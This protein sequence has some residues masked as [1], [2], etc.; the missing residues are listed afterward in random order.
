MTGA[1][2]LAHL[3][4]LLPAIV[5]VACGGAGEET[6]SPAPPASV[7]ATAPLPTPSRPPSIVVVDGTEEIPATPAVP[8]YFD[9]PEYGIQAFLFWDP[10]TAERD[11]ELIQE[12]GFGWVKQGFAWRDIEPF[13]G[14]EPDWWKPDKVVEL[15]EAA[16]LKP[17]VRIDRQPFWAQV[18]EWPPIENGPPADYE[19]FGAFCGRLAA[20]YR[21]RIHAYQVWNEPNLSREWGD[22]APDAAAYTELLRVCYEAIKAADPLAIVISA[23]LAPTGTELPEAIPD[24]EYLQA[25]YDAGASAYFDVLGLNAPGYKAPPELDPDVVADPEAGYGGNRWMSFR[26]VEDMRAIMEANGDADKQIAILEMGW[27]LEQDIHESYAWFGVDEEKQAEYLVNAYAYAREHW[28]PWIGLMTAVY[29]ADRDWTP[30]ANEQWW[31]AV[32]LPDGTPRLAYYALQ[33]MPK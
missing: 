27:I 23:G 32:V 11:I 16:D 28:Q 5:I 9:S 26:H 3:L 25:M 33:D 15:V 29:I 19:D 22:E 13:E 30:A 20:R 14:A 21:G 31:W 17:V 7:T 4:A 1:R 18:E 12:M 2:R 10:E 24:A 8:R 6:P